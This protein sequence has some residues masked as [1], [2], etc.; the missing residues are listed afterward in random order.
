MKSYLTIIHANQPEMLIRFK[1]KATH[2]LP[3]FTFRPSNKIY[4]PPNVICT[5]KSIILELIKVLI[6]ENKLQYD[7]IFWIDAS[8]QIAICYTFDK[9]GN[10]NNFFRI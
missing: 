4:Q 3:E 6:I 1:D 7:K 2:W 5:T 10:F 8:N 9:Q